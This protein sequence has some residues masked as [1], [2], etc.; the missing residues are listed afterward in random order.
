MLILLIKHPNYNFLAL[1]SPQ[2][3]TVNHSSG[4]ALFH[5]NFQLYGQQ[6]QDILGAALSAVN[7]IFKGKLTGEQIEQIQFR[8]KTIYAIYKPYFSVIYVDN[9]KNPFLTQVTAEFADNIINKFEK[10]ISTFNGGSIVNFELEIE[11]EMRRVFYFLPQ[12]IK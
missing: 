11:K 6:D 2:F 10:E 7:T 9:A 8:D 4:L 5:F 12:L 3:L 1:V